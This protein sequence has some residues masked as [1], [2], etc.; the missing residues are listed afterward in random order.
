MFPKPNTGTSYFILKCCIFYFILQEL[1]IYKEDMT[2]NILFWRIRRHCYDITWQS[3]HRLTLFYNVSTG[4]LLI[5]LYIEI[6][7]VLEVKD[8]AQPWLSVTRFVLQ[9]EVC[10]FLE[11]N[12]Q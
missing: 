3:R 12:I 9:E 4:P 1:K 5:P 7:Q 10:L 6:M 2:N 11:I 8:R